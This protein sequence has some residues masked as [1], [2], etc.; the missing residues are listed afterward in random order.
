MTPSRAETQDWAKIPVRMEPTMPP[1][2]WS[3]KTSRP[4][5][6]RS[7]LFMSVQR[8]QTTEVRKP[9]RQ[10]IQGETKPA[11]GVMPIVNS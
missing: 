2:P 11:A 4:S 8:A 7:H 1:I 10:A 9:I 3:L 5:S 6:M